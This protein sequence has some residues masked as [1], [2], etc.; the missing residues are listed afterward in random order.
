M[1]KSKRGP[2]FSCFIAIIIPNWLNRSIFFIN[3]RK[4]QTRIYLYNHI[5]LLSQL[6][7]LE[8]T[9]LLLYSSVKS[10]FIESGMRQNNVTVFYY[11]LIIDLKIRIK[12][13]GLKGYHHLLLKIN[14]FDFS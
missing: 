13:E 3:S 2:L 8:K 6:S 9:M 1:R 5:H 4:Y 10:Q 11:T 12:A 14:C 7:Y